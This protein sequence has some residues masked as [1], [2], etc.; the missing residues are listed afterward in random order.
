MTLWLHQFKFEW[1][2]LFA[3]KRTYLGFGAFLAVEVTI[4]LMLRLPSVQR[5][6]RRL[7]E[8]NGFVFEDYFSGT[9]LAVVMILWTVFLLGALYL[10]LVSG[11][12][13]GKEVEEGTFRMILC[14]P[15]SRGRIL[16]QKIVVAVVYT[17]V[18]CF[19]IG[20][21][22]LLMGLWER[23]YGGLF[24]YHPFENLFA[25]FPARE[26]VIRYFISLFFLSFSLLPIAMVGLFFSCF[27]MKPAAAT[28]LTLS[29]FFADNVFRNIP[30]FSSLR[31]WF[32]TT[33]MT[34]W[35]HIYQSV[36]PWED[37]LIKYLWLTGSMATLMIVAWIILERRDFKS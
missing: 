1:I 27:Q 26:G 21:T 10:A 23:G 3:K 36:I 6:V 2:R 17:F 13:V 33:Q 22:A 4:L 32:L 12:L 19:F 14:R 24:V 11:D 37:I 31:P 5:G 29:V 15:V 8:E 9:T 25:I 28:I 34:A 18:L 16:L 30:L 35:I 7:I 20:I